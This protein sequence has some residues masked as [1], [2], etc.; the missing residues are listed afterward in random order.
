MVNVLN[1]SFK[2]RETDM[3]NTYIRERFR[4]L[5]NNGTRNDSHLGIGRLE[6]CGGNT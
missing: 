6:F 4:I 1:K 2:E 3:K 5:E